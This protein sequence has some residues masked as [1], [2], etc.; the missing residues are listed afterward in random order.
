MPNGDQVFSTLII[1]IYVIFFGILLL[2]EL[3]PGIISSIGLAR[4]CNK[5]H[6]FRPVWSWVWSIFVPTVAILRAGDVAAQREDA[7]KRG[8]FGRGVKI[9]ITFAV[10]C[11]LMMLFLALAVAATLLAWP[12][13]LVYVCLIAVIVLT[14]PL[15][16]FSVWMIVLQF[17]SLYRIFKAFVPTWAAWLILAGMFVLQN[18]SFLV[19]PILSFVPLCQTA[20][21]DDDYRKDVL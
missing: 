5:L 15:L 9:L 19:L 3:L 14:G 6:A 4:I 17:I 2:I 12:S 8:H 18:F 20:P 16:V 1:L 11:T 13:M 21:R 10:L 7:Y